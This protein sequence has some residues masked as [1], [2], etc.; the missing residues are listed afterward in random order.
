MRHW[1]EEFGQIPG[2]QQHWVNADQGLQLGVSPHCCSIPSDSARSG[3]SPIYTCVEDHKYLLQEVPESAC[4]W[5]LTRHLNILLL[6]PCQAAAPSPHIPPH[7]AGLQC[8]S[9]RTREGFAFWQR[10]SPPLFRVSPSPWLSHAWVDILLKPC[11]GSGG[12]GR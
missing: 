1:E 12:E 4:A 6:P 2:D 5:P 7:H 11:G 9:P 3:S 10:V 8:R